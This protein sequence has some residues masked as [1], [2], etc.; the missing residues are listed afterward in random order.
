MI[1]FLKKSYIWIFILAFASMDAYEVRFEGFDDPKT[2]ELI[3]SVSQL[4][5]LKDTPPSTLIGLRR[6][7]END[8]THV[9]QVFHNF[10]HYNAKAN[11]TIEN[12]G[13]LIIVNV[14]PGPIYPLAVF[15]ISYVL[16][17][18]EQDNLPRC[19]ISLDDLQITIGDPATPESI[20]NAEDTL[21][22]QLNLQGYAFAKVIKKDAFA[23]QQAN[24][25]IVLIEVDTGPLTF[26]GPIR[27]NGLERV[28]ECFIRKKIRWQEGDLYD[29]KKI[30]LTQG[31]LDLSGL[32]KSVNIT[33]S[34]DPIDE[35]LMALDINVIEGKQRSI[36]FGVNFTT[37]FGPGISA[38]WEDRNI[39]G[40]G[41]KLSFKADLWA[42]LQNGSI[43][44]V[45]PDYK[46]ADQNLIWLLNYD[47]SRTKAFTESSF[48]LSA[49]IERRINAR[50]IASYGCMYKNLLSE[51]S[52]HNGTFNLLKTPLQLKWSNVDSI[53]DPSEGVTFHLKCIPTLQ[54]LDPQFA[55]CIN[56]LTTTYYRDLLD[57]K[58]HIL[59]SKL[60]LGSI[61]GAGKHD[62]PPPER[63]YAGSENTLRGYRYLTVSPIEEHH[64]HKPIGGRFLFVYSLELRNRITEDF[65]LVGFYDIGNVY[66]DSWPNSKRGLLQSAGL[67]IRYYTPVGPLRLDLAVPL[68]RRKHIDNYLEAYFSIGQTF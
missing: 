60:I 61:V 25:V 51:R 55:Y 18:E 34:S 43:S 67:G 28:N 59:A 20:L 5:K 49:T 11:F 52:E 26:F 7:A 66:F 47:H 8:M 42:K 56:T 10:A 2:L 63:F 50:L 27:I 17:G 12:K 64:H 41:E 23:D 31:T 21:I 36:G 62:I 46:R 48:S 58:R 40:G 3:H 16:N 14:D 33:Q 24:N 29:P 30:D 39:L 4:E 45:I 54:M 1:R 22:D 13:D 57:N 68:N 35:N 44:Y 38:E 37:Q 15:S 53:L 65:G 6:R 19:P 9:I 32:F